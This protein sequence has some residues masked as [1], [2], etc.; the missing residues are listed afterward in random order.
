MAVSVVFETHSTSEDNER[1]IGTG[2]LGGVLSAAGREQA[3]ELGRRRRVDG[4]D[5]VIASDLNRAV[6]TARIAFGD[7]DIPVRLDWRL[8]ECD[9]GDLNG[10]PASL[11]GAERM[12]HLERPFPGGE[13]WQGAV[14]R[15]CGLLDELEKTREGE[16]VLLIGHGA[17]LF[18]LEHYASGVSI[19]ALV[20]AP[21][22]WQEGWEYRLGV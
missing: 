12:A 21:F 20:E 16:R 2:W 22:H 15:V 10:T 19:A 3:R 4:L 11:I 8:R 14:L 17:T 6:E 18:A 13:S 5:V 1:G 9:Y 7:T